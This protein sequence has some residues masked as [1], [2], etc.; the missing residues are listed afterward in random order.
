MN[1]PLRNLKDAVC[2]SPPVHFQSL[3]G[4]RVLF[5]DDEPHIREAVA[6]IL[7]A[8][9][10][11]TISAESPEQ[12]VDLLTAK[13][14]E[15]DIMIIDYRLKQGR[16]GVAAIEKL[17]SHFDR[18]IPAII[19]TGDTSR[20]ILQAARKT[21]CRLLHKPLDASVLVQTIAEVLNIEDL[22]VQ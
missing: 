3:G 10:C 15:P 20:E 4:I 12:A 13:A 18:S 8:F 21:G 22:A 7:D 14:V 19:V 5:I 1:V 6:L 11:L 2:S 16:T 9:Q 17:W